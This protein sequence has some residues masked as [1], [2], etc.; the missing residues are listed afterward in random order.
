MAANDQIVGGGGGVAGQI[1]QPVPPVATPIGFKDASGNL[2]NGAVDSSGNLKV[3]VTGAGSGG[4]SSVDE[5]AFTAGTT[6]GTPAMGVYESSPTPLTSGQLGIV[7]LDADR[8]LCV[9]VKAGGSGGGAVT[10]ADGADVT[11]GA[12]ADAAVTGDNSG[13]VSAKLRGISKILADVWDSANH[14]FKVSI[15]NTTLAVTQSGSWSVTAAQSTFASLKATVTG[16]GTA[17]TADAGVVTVQGIASM[18][19]L[20]VTPDLPSGAATS[21]NQT[22][23]TQ[24]TQI[25]DGSGNVI[26]STSNA[27]NV[28]ISSGNPTTIAVTQATAASLNATVIQSATLPVTLARVGIAASSSGD[29]I[30]IAAVS[31]KKTYVYAF[32]LS[33]SGTV[34][35]KFT[36]G[37]AGTLLGGLYYGVANA[38]AA[39][40]VGPPYYLWVGSTNTALELN[41]S[42]AV[43]VGGGISYWQA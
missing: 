34:N 15:Q 10:V 4:T 21:A 30:V 8:N 35:A 38:G 28:N 11:Q 2:Q 5:A 26:A 6:A 20:L 32:E 29:N 12:I 3:A 16:N 1:G 19:K 9:N 13:T 23:A 42:G 25:V 7:E 27:L 37:A 14:W 31:G 22:N 43:A 17:G 40:T 24:K 41:L 33:F 39:Q 36:D 18:T